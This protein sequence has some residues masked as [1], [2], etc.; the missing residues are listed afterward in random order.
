MKRLMTMM[1]GVMAVVAAWAGNSR[2]TLSDIYYSDTYGGWVVELGLDNPDETVNA[3]QC[4]IAIPSPFVFDVGSYAFTER[5]LE[6]KMGKYVDTHTC[7]SAVRS[8]GCLRVLVYSSENKAIKGT[9]GTVLVLALKDA[10]QYFAIPHDHRGNANMTNIA[11]TRSVD[12]Q[13][14]EE[15]EYPEAVVNDSTLQC[16][17]CMDNAAFVIGGVTAGELEE[18]NVNLST[19]VRLVTVDLTRCSDATLGTLDVKNGNTIIMAAGEKQVD[20]EHNVFWKENGEW[21]CNSFWLTDE[22]LSLSLPF[23]ARARKFTYDRTYTGGVWNT[24]CLPVALTQ[25][26]YGMLKERNVVVRQMTSFD[27]EH[28]TV[29]F[30]DVTDF[31]PNVPYVIR[32]E[33]DGIVFSAIE[34]VMLVPSER[35]NIVSDNLVMS[36]NYDYMVINST[37]EQARYG[38]EEGT[39]EF[40]K[41]GQNCIL[42]PFRCFLELEAGLSSA[43]PRIYILQQGTD[44]ISGVTSDGFLRGAFGDTFAD[45]EVYSADGRRVAVCRD[46]DTGHLCLPA[47]VYVIGGRKVVIK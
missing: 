22:G 35:V 5:A 16:Y 33:E 26:Q 19:N 28:A 7:S 37:S 30:S 27:S 29:T 8:N 18:I 40:V 9:D 4:D 24:V 11:L 15:A 25:E 2:M 47:G 38:Y 1:I 23:S 31:Q 13:I 43:K 45:L 17:N 46:G 32:P 3:F 6:L 42:K 20:N 14:V 21:M 41:L 39:G 34:N 44:G 10:S 12:G 36:G